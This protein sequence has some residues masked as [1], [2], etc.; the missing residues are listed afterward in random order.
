[1]SKE[2]D[3]LI[4]EKDEFYTQKLYDFRVTKKT[5]VFCYS[6]NFGSFINILSNNIFKKYTLSD[7]YIENLS[8]DI[9]LDLISK[10][11][12]D[13]CITLRDIKD[14]LLTHKCK[15]NISESRPNEWDYMA[16]SKWISLS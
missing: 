16:Y 13:K 14:V 9:Y 6:S 7:V 1:M 4:P 8:D 11:A 10:Y 5:L 3:F 15:I 12:I 2:L